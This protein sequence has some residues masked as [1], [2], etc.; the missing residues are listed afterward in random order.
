MLLTVCETNQCAGCMS[1]MDICPTNSITIKD[2]LKF[3]NAVINSDTCIKCGLCHK[4][5]QRNHPAEV[6]KPQSWYQGWAEE[7]IRSTSSSGGFG[8]ELMRSFI[9][10]GGVVA[11]CKLIDGDFKFA[12]ADSI[13]DLKKLTGSKY[14]KS[15]PVG[16]CKK[17]TGQLKKNKKVLFIGLPCQVSSMRNFV[18]ENLQQNLYTVDLICHGSPSVKLLQESL[19]EY[20][21]DIHQ[22]QEVL[23]R[24]NVRFGLETDLKKV[25]PEGVQDCYTMAFLRGLDY[26]EN[27]YSCHY[28]QGSRV[29]DLTMGD[30]WGTEYNDELQKGISLILCQTE[31]G[32]EL[33]D[34]MNFTF[35][36]V[37]LD[38]AIKNNIQLQ[39]PSIAPKQRDQFFNNLD[40]GMSFNKAVKKAYPKDCLKQDVKSVFIKLGWH[41]GG[42][43][44]MYEIGVIP[45]K[46]R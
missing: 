41:R 15:N 32:K 44:V 2:N 35:K 33:L 29:G 10:N 1:C 37:N 43:T 4:V 45:N 46:Q 9:S 30:S 31:K 20:G 7:K 6:R 25:V 23:F 24:K 28:A 19:K 40:K 38:N 21:Y 11:A 27:C 13:L 17:V 34:K 26:T 14:V 16:I 22:L 18:S 5:C 8:Q 3:M 39:H 36:E 12:I 42:D